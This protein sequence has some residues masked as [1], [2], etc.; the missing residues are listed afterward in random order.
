MARWS[1][2]MILA[3]GARGVPGSTHGRIKT[4]YKNIYIQQAN[5]NT[6][7]QYGKFFT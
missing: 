7:Y 6:D 3:K 1:S 5:G 2:G 4:N